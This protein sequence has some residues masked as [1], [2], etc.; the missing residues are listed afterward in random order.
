M[1][2]NLEIINQR[3]IE[4][5]DKTRKIN[6]T[7]LF[8]EA[9]IDNLITAINDEVKDFDAD[10]NTKEGRAKIISLA[11]KI[12]KC[13]TPVKNL[14]TE[15]KEDSKKLIDGV[16][17]QWNRYEKAMDELR[18][19]IRKPVDEIEEKIEKH[20]QESLSKIDKIQKLAFF[21]LTSSDIKQAIIEVQQIYS[22]FGFGEFAFKAENDKITAINYLNERLG[23]ALKAEADALE[24][25]KLQEEKAERERKD[26]ELQIA[27]EAEE[28]AKREAEAK[29]LQI[30]KEKE[31][32]EERAKKAE[33]KAK[34]DAIIAE[35]NRLL[36]EKKA[37]EDAQKA[38]N[39][40]IE[41][42]RKR[43]AEEARLEQEKLE[44]REANKRHQAKIHNEIYVSLKK[45]LSIKFNV[46][47]RHES[48]EALVE[49]IKAIAKNEIPH[50][51]I[52]Y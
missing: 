25:K 19:K 5:L 38:I 30:Q 15:L 18:D 33:E 3:E 40:A 47:I 34:Q 37:K 11:A 46:E 27:R 1:E 39:D 14:A 32:A 24:L 13:K 51:Q 7:N 29:Q 42:E 48:D 45:V 16:N 52:N 8:S 4:L 41:A 22:N 36:A 9:G 44:K 23:I 28:K 35:E 10:V 21:G 43:V 2:N 6:L 20:K 26:R 50:I 17:Y 31:E 12:A 49:I